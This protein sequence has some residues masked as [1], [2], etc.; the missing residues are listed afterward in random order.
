MIENLNRRLA[1]KGVAVSLSPS[2]KKYLISK[3]YD[4]KYGARPLRRTVQDELETAIAEQ[5]IEKKIKRGD[6]LRANYSG[7]KIFL[8]KTKETARK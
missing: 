6:I 5:M 7:G 2:A 1:A 3:G 8:T 4:P